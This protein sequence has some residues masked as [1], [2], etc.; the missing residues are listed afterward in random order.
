MAEHNIRTAAELCRRLNALGVEV[1]SIYLSRMLNERP[2][3]LNTDLLD[4][5]MTIFN[6]TPND[7]LPVIEVLEDEDEVKEPISTKPVVE[8]TRDVIKKSVSSNVVKFE[9]KETGKKERK[10][11]REDAP[12]VI[13]GPDTYALPTEETEDEE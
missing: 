9:K 4:A 5:F 6:C 8:K 12:E 11:K 2:T 10:R 3:R 1:T 13:L 7:L